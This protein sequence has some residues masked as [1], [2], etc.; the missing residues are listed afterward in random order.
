MS[1]SL[2]DL[3][4]E[5]RS[6]EQQASHEDRKRIQA[7]LKNAPAPE[8]QAFD[9][10]YREL[11]HSVA[12]NSA[13]T[14]NTNLA[15]SMATHSRK[16]VLENLARWF[17]RLNAVRYILCGIDRGEDFA[18]VVPDLTSWL[19]EWDLEGVRAS[20]DLT[21]GQSVVDFEV[22]TRRRTDRLQHTS[23]FHSEVRW[24]HGRFS[25]AVESKLYKEFAWKDLPFLPRM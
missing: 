9:A 12:Q 25:G 11:S 13:A 18:V 6:F 20:P 1:A 14:F 16:G 5:V 3:P 10:R 8:Q 19:R 2:A 4:S 23:R 17:F 21:R 22:T 24:S 7:V 15:S